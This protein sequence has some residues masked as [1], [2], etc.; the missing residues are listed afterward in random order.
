MLQLT[1]MTWTS[2][3]YLVS[4]F[5]APHEITLSKPDNEGI[6]ISSS[7]TPPSGTNVA[8][9]QA[10]QVGLLPMSRLWIQV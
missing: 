5:P 10:R 3:L 7:L 8:L 2:S 9:R 1:Q 4:L 6:L